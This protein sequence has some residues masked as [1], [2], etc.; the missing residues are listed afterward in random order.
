MKKLALLLLALAIV[1][2]AFADDA[3]V[4]PAGV[5][6]TYLLLAQ[7]SYDETYDDDGDTVDAAFGGVSAWSTGI[8]LEYG[9]TDQIT[10]ALQWTPAWIFSSSFGDPINLGA[11]PNDD[12]NVNG[13]E[14]LFIG[15]KVQIVGTN[16]FVVNDAMR[17]AAAA[18]IKIPL[19]QYDAQDEQDAYIA[20]DEFTFSP[21]SKQALGYGFRLYYDYLVT[22]SFWI[23]LYNETIFYAPV[24]K[25]SILAPGTDVEYEYGY[26][27]TLE[28]EPHYDYKVDNTLTLSAA[29]PFT[30][31]KMPESEEDGVGQD[32]ESNL[33]TLGPNVSAFWTGG[34]L[35]MELEVGYALPLM[36]KNNPASKTFTVIFKSYMKF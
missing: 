36:G 3:K 34:P 4:L 6:R 24:E 25:D 26:D 23:N 11:G 33:L 20:G 29:L 12:G 14:D 28:V 1:I 21:T 9:V 15:A 35:P 17:F 27:L 13:L 19:A 16:G 32:D 30:Y 22:D 10:A 5:L 7:S 8:A 2:P 18:G 31:T